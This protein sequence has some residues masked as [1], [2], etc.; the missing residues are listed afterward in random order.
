MHILDLI[1]SWALRPAERE[2]S[3][4]APRFSVRHPADGGAFNALMLEGRVGR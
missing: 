1:A 3:D 4:A 2:K